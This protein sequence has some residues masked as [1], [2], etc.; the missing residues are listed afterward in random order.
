MPLRHVSLPTACHYLLSTTR[1]YYMLLTTRCHYFL[2][3]TA[4][5]PSPLDHIDC[6]PRPHYITPPDLNT[7]LHQ[8]SIH[9]STRPQY[10]TPPDL[11]HHHS[12]SQVSQFLNM[13]GMHM[14]SRTAD[15]IRGE[16]HFAQ[17]ETPFCSTYF[18]CPT[19]FL[20]FPT[21]PTPRT[22]R[23]YSDC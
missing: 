3:T 18:T 6:S 5:P 11:I 7:S 20:Y 1:C 16:E 19:S 9:H 13:G 4:L 21:L 15:V 12:L 14:L 2:T 23:F 10:I 17:V 8:T 22:L